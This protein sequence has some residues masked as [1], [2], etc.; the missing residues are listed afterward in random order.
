[1]QKPSAW[2]LGFLAKKFLGFLTF[3]AKILAINLG[4][5]RKN[6]LDFSRSWKGIQENFWTSGK[7]SKNNQDLGKRNKKSLHQSNTRSMDI[8]QA[9]ILENSKK[10]LPLRVLLS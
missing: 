7:K 8:L 1:M 2:R 6:L 3:L 5:V 4:K 9:I 10:G